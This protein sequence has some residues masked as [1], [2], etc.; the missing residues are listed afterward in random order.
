MWAVCVVC[1]CGGLGFILSV[2]QCTCIV[3]SCFENIRTIPHTTINFAPSPP[4]LQL[5]AYQDPG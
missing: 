2:R 1:V 4:E 5:S 3:V